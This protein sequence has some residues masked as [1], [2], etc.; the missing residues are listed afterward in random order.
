MQLGPGI[1][2]T[3]PNL[4]GLQ[5]GVISLPEVQQFIKGPN[6]YPIGDLAYAQ[7]V[8]DVETGR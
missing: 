5:N 7:Q 8:R 4:V 6:Y 1:L 3:M 2:E